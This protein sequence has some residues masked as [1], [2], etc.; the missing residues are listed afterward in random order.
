MPIPAHPL[1]NLSVAQPLPCDS[2][3]IRDATV[4]LTSR[5]MVGTR[6]TYPSPWTGA[7]MQTLTAEQPRLKVL[8][9]DDEPIIAKTLALILKANGFDAAFAL[10][11]EAAVQAARAGCPD[12][13]VLDVYMRGITGIETA[14]RIRTLN[15]GCKTILISG[16][17]PDPELLAEIAL[18]GGD[19]DVLIKPFEPTQLLEKLRPLTSSQGATPETTAG[20]LVSSLW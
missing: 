19:V 14:S 11:G 16:A 13:L 20:A 10:S 5:Q 2:P 1:R 12:A 9:A 17:T 6:T 18:L 3:H 7:A 4:Q 8:I 15:P